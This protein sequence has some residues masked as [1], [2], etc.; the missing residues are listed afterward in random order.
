MRGGGGGRCRPRAARKRSVQ[1]CVNDNFPAGVVKLHGILWTVPNG[2][3]CPSG[4]PSR[5]CR[6]REHSPNSIIGIEQEDEAIVITT[7]DIHLPRRIGAAVKRAFHGRL[8][9][10][11]D[12]AGYFA[13][14]TWT[15][16][17]P[18]A[19][20][21]NLLKARLKIV[22]R[23]GDEPQQSLPPDAGD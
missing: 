4:A 1:R 20:G 14:V 2:R 16:E 3:D 22:R 17:G 21:A 11:F 8:E 5:G 6:K 18:E 15:A 19:R 12:D 7:T 10:D 13:R 9:E 23:P